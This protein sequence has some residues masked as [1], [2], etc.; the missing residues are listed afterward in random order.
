M[1]KLQE[2]PSAFKREHSA[3]QNMKILNF[4]LFLWVIFALLD[5]DPLA[6]VE[7]LRH[8]LRTCR[9]EEEREQALYYLQTLNAVDFSCFTNAYINSHILYQVP[10]LPT[11]VPVISIINSLCSEMEVTEIILVKVSRLCKL[12]NHSPGFHSRILKG[13]VA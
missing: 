12:S 13:T 7:L 4:F 1:S 9:C 3:L 6:L 11:S 5:P 8:I 2:K 10:T